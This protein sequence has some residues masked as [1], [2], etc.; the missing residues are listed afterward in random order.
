MELLLV[1][2]YVAICYAVFKTFQDTGKSVD[3][4]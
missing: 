2:T 3:A 1:L 4:C